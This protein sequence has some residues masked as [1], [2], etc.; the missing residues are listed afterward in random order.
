MMKKYDL[1]LT[2]LGILF[3]ISSLFFNFINLFTGDSI[4][5]V[6]FGT[7]LSI[8]L[9]ISVLSYSAFVHKNVN[10]TSLKSN[11]LSACSYGLFAYLLLHIFIGNKLSSML[12]W[13]QPGYVALFFVLAFALNL[14]TYAISVAV[15]LLW[16]CLAKTYFVTGSITSAFNNYEVSSQLQKNYIFYI[17]VGFIIFLALECYGNYLSKDK[18]S[19]N[20]SGSKSTANTVDDAFHSDNTN[21]YTNNGGQHKFFKNNYKPF[22]KTFDHLSELFKHKSP[23]PD[24]LSNYEREDSYYN[25]T[26]T[27]QYANSQQFTNQNHTCERCGNPHPCYCNECCSTCSNDEENCTCQY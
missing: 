17:I 5:I 3:P 26:Y 10:S 6:P 25:N 23:E 19:T 9:T 1:I 8:G 13:E 18:S 12:S 11:F 21:Y 14:G 7:S 24:P 27:N 2:A 20:T 4:V 16:I 15:S 22:R